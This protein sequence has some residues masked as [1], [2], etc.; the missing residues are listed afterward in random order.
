MWNIY[1]NLGVEK[2][3]LNKIQK[4]INKGKFDKFVL[5]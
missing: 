1:V 3:F 2:N 4:Q 5:Y